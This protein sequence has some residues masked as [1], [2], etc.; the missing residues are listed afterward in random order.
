M[1]QHRFHEL[2]SVA[3]FGSV[4]DML[5][6]S[7]VPVSVTPLAFSLAAGDFGWYVLRLGTDYKFYISDHW[8]LEELRRS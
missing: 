3:G 7:R 4:R 6:L 1:F 8:P 2:D 5:D